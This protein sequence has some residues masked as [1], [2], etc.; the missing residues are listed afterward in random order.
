MKRLFPFVL[1]LCSL[2]AFAQHG[3]YNSSPYDFMWMNL[4]NPDFS[5]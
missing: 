4:G 5:G 2:I 1:L 3:W